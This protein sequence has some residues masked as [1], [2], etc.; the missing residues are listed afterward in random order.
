MR[1]LLFTVTI[2]F[3]GLTG[4]FAFF[5]VQPSANDTRARVVLNIDTSAMSTA[6]AANKASSDNLA[7]AASFGDGK[8]TEA[9]LGDNNEARLGD[10]GEQPEQA[11]ATE[12]TSLD[13]PPADDNAKHEALPLAGTV[14]SS[15]NEN[16]SLDAQTDGSTSTPGEQQ[17]LPGTLTDESV[18]NEQNAA[19]SEA[20]DA[21][22]GANEN[23][24]PAASASAS[25]NEPMQV[26]SKEAPYASSSETG[27]QHDKQRTPDKPGDTLAANLAALDEPYNAPHSSDTSAPASAPQAASEATDAQITE[28]PDAPVAPPVAAQEKTASATLAPPP[29]PARRPA[30]VPTIQTA[31]LTTAPFT[32]TETATKQVRVAILIRGIGRNSLDSNAAIE[33]LP[34]AISLGFESSDE[35]IQQWAAKAKERGHEVIVQLPLEPMGASANMSEE[36]LRSDAEPL[37]NMARLNTVLGRFNGPNGVTNTMGDKLLQSEKALQPILEDIKNRGLMYIAVGKRRHRLFRKIADKMN[38]RYGNASLVIDIQPTP[39]AI[40]KALQRL[41]AMARKNGSAIGIAS[42]SNVTIE[43]LQAWSEELATSGVT[44]VPVGALAQSPGAS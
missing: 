27:K 15:G 44:L 19:A 25:P 36:M 2:F 13:T 33:N 17:Q 29:I 37:Q 38:L 40:K 26:A 8:D 35:G 42:V 1:V 28:V 7:S 31:A 41:V 5:A 16:A 43:Q 34:S 6:E 11:P 18:G 24:A 22:I 9:R 21:N 10:N 30:N 39:D 14:V 3:V 4:L 20:P 32:T 23:E 12:T